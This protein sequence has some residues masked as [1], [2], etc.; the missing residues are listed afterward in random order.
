MAKT[1]G[2]GCQDFEKLRTNG[3]FYI[4]TLKSRM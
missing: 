4:L 3:N 2:I 1:V